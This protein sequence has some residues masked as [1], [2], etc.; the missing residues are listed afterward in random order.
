MKPDRVEVFVGE[1]ITLDCQVNIYIPF[2]VTLSWSGPISRGSVFVVN[3][4]TTVSDRLVV[5]AKESYN[6]QVMFCNV[7]VNGTIYSASATLI[8]RGN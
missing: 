5:P 4:T 1:N 6:G 2:N 8:V 7:S 3:E